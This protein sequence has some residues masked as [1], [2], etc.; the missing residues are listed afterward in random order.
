MPNGVWTGVNLPGL[1][2]RMGGCGARMWKTLIGSWTWHGSVGMQGDAAQRGM[3]AEVGC[4]WGRGR[5][6]G[7]IA[8]ARWH[9]PWQVFTRGVALEMETIT[10]KEDDFQSTQ[11]HSTLVNQRLRGGRAGREV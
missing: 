4:E 5:Y 8:A 1:G 7:D 10:K 2:M 6:K 11:P 9:G 3:Q